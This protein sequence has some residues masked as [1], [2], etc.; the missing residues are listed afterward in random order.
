MTGDNQDRAN[1]AFH[2]GML[3]G[4]ARILSDQAASSLTRSERAAMTLRRTA[5]WIADQYQL[6]DTLTAY[7]DGEGER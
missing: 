7:L 3:D 6:T 1:A 4:V 2:V 5:R